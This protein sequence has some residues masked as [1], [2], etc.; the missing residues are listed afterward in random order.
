MT[1]EHNKKSELDEDK[2]DCEV[3]LEEYYIT[4]H[5]NSVQESLSLFRDDPL[6]H[7]PG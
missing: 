6:I 3:L 2:S 7:K 5:Y 4:N 1:N